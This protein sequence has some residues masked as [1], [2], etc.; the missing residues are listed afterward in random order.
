MSDRIE[1]RLVADGSPQSFLWRERLY[2]VRQHVSRVGNVWR[3]R[4]SSGGHAADAFYRSGVF[5]LSYDETG[6]HL[7]EVQ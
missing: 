5:D 2:I 6:W 3:V 7:T 1:I 4:A